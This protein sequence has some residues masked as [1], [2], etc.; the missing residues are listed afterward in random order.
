MFSNCTIGKPC[1]DTTANVSSASGLRSCPCATILP[2]CANMHNPANASTMLPGSKLPFVCT[3]CNPPFSLT[4]HHAQC[5]APP[6]PSPFSS[7]PCFATYT[8]SVHHKG[9]CCTMQL[10]QHACDLCRQAIR[11]TQAGVEGRVWTLWQLDCWMDCRRR[12]S[13][14]LRFCA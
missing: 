5:Y 14:K 6:L 8:L 9:R 2:A 11:I 3:H 7:T 1:Y 13:G 4:T 12:P 10:A